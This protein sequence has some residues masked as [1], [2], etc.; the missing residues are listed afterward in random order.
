M[1]LPSF[2]LSRALDVAPA[3][4]GTRRERVWSAGRVRG[5]VRM[6]THAC[7]RKAAACAHAHR[8]GATSRSR[9]RMSLPLAR[10]A[11]LGLVGLGV[12]DRHGHDLEADD[13]HGPA[14][15]LLVVLDD[16]LDVVEEEGA[17][18]AR[19]ARDE[20]E[21]EAALVGHL[22]VIRLVHH[23]HGRGQAVEHPAHAV[24]RA[25]LVDEVL[26]LLR[27]QRLLAQHVAAR[28]LAHDELV[29]AVLDAV[30]D[31]HLAD[32]LALSLDLPASRATKEGAGAGEGKEGVR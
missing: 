11:G 16:E 25:D 3:G 21:R 19:G 22:V 10:V 12:L 24:V 14:G 6:R 13:A 8:L 27:V 4:E 32:V 28:L 31:Q 26:H 17:R 18:L 9:A 5:T 30:A 20:A 23:A 29:V 2:R 15:H 7:A 1:L